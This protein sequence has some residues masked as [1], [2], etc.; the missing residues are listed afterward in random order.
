MGYLCLA[1]YKND[2]GISEVYCIKF[3]LRFIKILMI[4]SQHIFLAY[5]K[6]KSKA[7]WFRGNMK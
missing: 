7:H 4:K 5:Y 3:S 1:S 6:T 2:C